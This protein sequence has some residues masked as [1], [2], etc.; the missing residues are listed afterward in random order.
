MRNDSVKRCDLAIAFILQDPHK[1]HLLGVVRRGGVVIVNSQW[2]CGSAKTAEDTDKTA[3]ESLHLI[4]LEQSLFTQI[5]PLQYI[6]K[7]KKK[8]PEHNKNHLDFFLA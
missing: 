4:S 1:S 3:K 6:K 2:S 8:N 7:R 5:S